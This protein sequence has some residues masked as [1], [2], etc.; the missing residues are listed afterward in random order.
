MSEIPS[1]N[2]LE[3]ADSPPVEPVITA[4]NVELPAPDQLE[5]VPLVNNE[6]C[7]PEEIFSALNFRHMSLEWESWGPYMADYD[8][9]NGHL[10]ADNLTNSDRIGIAIAKVIRDIFPDSQFISLYDDYNTGVADS[11]DVWGRPQASDETGNMARQLPVS[12]E[13]KANFLSDMKSILKDQGIA[14]DSNSK[15][16]AESEKQADAEVLVERLRERGLIEQAGQEIHFVNPQAENK[17]LQ[18]ITLRTKNGRWL[19]P[20]LDASSFLDPENFKNIVHLVILPAQQFQQQQDQVWEILRA[21]D[22][23]PEH[24]H[25]IFFDENG[26]PDEISEQIRTLFESSQA[27]FEQSTRLAA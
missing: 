15:L 20:A 7:Q 27:D 22:L 4:T 24:Y 16:I 14:D 10:N 2:D 21:L 1:K 26:D 8:L 3:I 19:C 11:A 23:R 6:K 5:T 12:P 25:N 13:A 18:R 9:A 17:S